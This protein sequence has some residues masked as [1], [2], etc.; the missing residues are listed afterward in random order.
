[1]FLASLLIGLREGLE[2]SLIIGVL[3][4][5]LG[6]LGRRDSL[7]PMWSGVIIALV[8]TAAI[9]AVSTFGRSRLT[10]RT[11]EII[12]G[13]M[14]ILAVVMITGMIFWMLNAG[15]K[16]NSMLE[17]DIDK[18]RAR[19]KSVGYAVF[20]VA[21]ISVGREGIET[22]IILWGWV[23]EPLAIM[24]ALTGVIVAVALGWAL[25]KG[26]VRFNLSTFFTWSG[27]ALIVV[28]GGV[29]AY[30][31]HDL[32][33]AAVLP[34]PFSGAPIT[35]THPRTGEVLTGFFT[36]P[37]WGAAFPFGWA[38]DISDVLD[39]SGVLATFLKGTVGFVPQMSWLEV[40]AWFIYMVLV[41]PRFIRRAREA[42]NP[43]RTEANDSKPV[44]HPQS[45]STS[46]DNL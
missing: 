18:L 26:L 29:L 16:M 7:R 25:F 6:K 22:T 46:E 37:F 15:K 33:E 35:P 2:A 12:G 20:F 13:S 17:G 19:R 1:M 39:P 36:Y 32:Q 11:Q 3:V 21:F 4:A 34:G 30:G 31:I 45:V 14:S 41:I 9:G 38:F 24:G 10:F 43:R 40:L 28:A 5:Y 42:K 44:P 27:A 8:L 23:N